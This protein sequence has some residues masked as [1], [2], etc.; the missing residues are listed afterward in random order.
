M[1]QKHRII[2]LKCL[3]TAKLS[4]LNNKA[5]LRKV[6]KIFNSVPE[7]Y[8]FPVKYSATSGIFHLE[9][10]EFLVFKF[11]KKTNWQQN[12]KNKK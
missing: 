1:F 6:S 7:A 2:P 4:N 11:C 3:T 10:I 9:K 5:R 8:F 12:K